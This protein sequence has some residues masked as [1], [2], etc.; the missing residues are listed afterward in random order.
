MY[1]FGS[2]LE[3]STNAT[4]CGNC[5][6]QRSEGILSTSQV[7]L[8]EAILHS[9]KYPGIPDLHTMEPDEVETYLET[10]LVWRANIAIQ[11]SKYSVSSA[12]YSVVNIH[13]P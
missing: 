11:V 8:T 7:P 2:K 6:D 9:V 13:G 3:D 10:H 1:T 12:E 5:L 4:R